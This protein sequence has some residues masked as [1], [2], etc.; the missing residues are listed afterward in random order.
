MSFYTH[1]CAYL[2]ARTLTYDRSFDL[3]SRIADPE[4][5]FLWGFTRSPE[6]DGTP[7]GEVR[8]HLPETTQTL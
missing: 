1:L 8:S 3:L 5:V 2:V 6:Q 7:Q 4:V